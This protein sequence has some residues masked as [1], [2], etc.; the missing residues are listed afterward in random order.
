MTYRVPFV[1]PREHYRRLKPEVDAVITGTLAKGDLVLRQ[2]LRD[3]L[4]YTS[5]SPRDS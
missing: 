3:C 5:P 2:Q 1:D 4:L